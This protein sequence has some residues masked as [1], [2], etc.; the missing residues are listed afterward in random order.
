M[1]LSD[2]TLNN[3][4]DEVI[5]THKEPLEKLA[6]D[7]K[8]ECVEYPIIYKV[9]SREDPT[10]VVGEVIRTEENKAHMKIY[11]DT[12]GGPFA[13][14]YCREEGQY[15]IGEKATEMLLRERV[16]DPHYQGIG[17]YLRE[18]GLK[19]WD[20]WTLI[21]MDKGI[22]SR[23]RFMIIKEGIDIDSLDEDD[24]RIS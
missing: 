3:I 20:L 23:D 4:L 14:I 11:P 19:Y 12:E 10:Y 16:I 9:V 7:I 15:E 21:E 13:F 1:T 24:Y 6:G 17:W 18:K 8:K 2:D 22:C 5:E